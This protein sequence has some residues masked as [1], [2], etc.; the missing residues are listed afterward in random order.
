M[1][2]CAIV[3]PRHSCE[4]ALPS[5][6]TPGGVTLATPAGLLSEAMIR[7]LPERA[8][9]SQLKR[10]IATLPALVLVV[11]SFRAAALLG[12]PVVACVIN[13]SEDFYNQAHAASEYSSAMEERLGAISTAASTATPTF[14]TVEQAV[15]GANL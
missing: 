11:P 6:V 12:L 14:R 10:R 3:A 7:Q 13:A 2:A 1:N 15:I 4:R 9:V 5:T 8:L